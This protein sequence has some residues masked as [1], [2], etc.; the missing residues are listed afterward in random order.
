MK[1][2]R[3]HENIF[4]FGHWIFIEINPPPLTHY[5]RGKTFS[6]RLRQK[7]SQIWK[8]IFFPIKFQFSLS[9][10]VKSRTFWIIP[11]FSLWKV[12]GSCMHFICAPPPLY[13]SFY[14]FPPFPFVY[15]PPFPSLVY[16]R[17]SLYTESSLL[18]HFLPVLYSHLLFYQG[19]PTVQDYMFS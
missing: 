7:S 16:L 17:F 15:L 18:D 1:Q 9:K 11:N 14:T 4:K 6:K 5:F 2:F 10:T 19:L 8:S 3:K 12:G 13:S